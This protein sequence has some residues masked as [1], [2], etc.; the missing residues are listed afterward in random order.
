[1]DRKREGKTPRPTRLVPGGHRSR[2]A[3]QAG[4]P[5]RSTGGSRPSA[6]RSTHS[7][8]P[9][10]TQKMRFKEQQSRERAASE[11]A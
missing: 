8:T 9:R 10:W 5:G 1:M 7:S 6:K 11:K 3:Q 4:G 2:S